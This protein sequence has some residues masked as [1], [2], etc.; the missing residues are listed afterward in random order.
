MPKAMILL[1]LAICS[2]FAAAPPAHAQLQP[3]VL[4][5]NGNDPFPCSSAVNGSKFYAG[6]NCLQATISQCPG[7][8]DIN[9][10]FGWTGPAAPV[11]TIVFFSGD[12]GVAPTESGD[13]IPAYAPIYVNTFEIVYVE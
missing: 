2:T 11:G 5:L 9:I 8:E 12:G 1:L 3:G 10:T 13:D 6:M 7:V 4:T